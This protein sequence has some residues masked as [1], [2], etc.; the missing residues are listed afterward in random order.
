MPMSWEGEEP[1]GSGWTRREW[2]KLAMAAGAASSIA[3]LAGTVSGQ[4]LPPPMKFEGEMREQMYYT[5]WPTEAWWNSR[6]GRV[7]RVTDFEE[8]KG[9]SGV[10]RGLFLDGQWVPGTGYPVLVIRL[11]NDTP[12]FVVATTSP[13]RAV[14]RSITTTRIRRSASWRS[15]TDAPTSVALPDGT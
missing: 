13:L 5:K 11:K 6:Q 15:S 14:S 1:N 7:I 10:W 8:W 12:E 2:A 9:A 4:L 3:A